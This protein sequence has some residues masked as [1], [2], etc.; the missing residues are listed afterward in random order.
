MNKPLIRDD[1]PVPPRARGRPKS[2]RWIFLETLKEGQSAH[3]P[4]DTE[5]EVG[6]NE[7]KKFRSCLFSMITRY[8]KASGKTFTVRTT[9]EGVGVWRT[10]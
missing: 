9:D 7:F 1:I 4:F 8:Q 3:F 6:I 10:K 2:S 5:S